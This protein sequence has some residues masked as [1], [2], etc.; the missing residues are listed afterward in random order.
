MSTVNEIGN[1]AWAS[2]SNKNQKERQEQYLELM[3][4]HQ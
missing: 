4:M 3:Y 1:F 2:D